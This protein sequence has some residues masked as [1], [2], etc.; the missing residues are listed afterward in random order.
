MTE[1]KPLFYVNIQADTYSDLI[2]E[3]AR[4]GEPLLQAALTRLAA[5]L[6]PLSTGTSPQA[7]YY[8]PPPAPPLSTET[9]E[10]YDT[11]DPV[12][13]A[14]AG[15]LEAV[16]KP[17]RRAPGRPPKAAPPAEAPPPKSTKVVSQKPTGDDPEPEQELSLE[18]KT[19]ILSSKGK[20]VYMKTG[21]QKQLQEIYGRYNLASK[22]DALQAPAEVFNR[23]VADLDAALAAEPPEMF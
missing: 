20:A 6:P 7:A 10:S 19:A 12:E 13:A 15:P 2:G 21:D 11:R 1:H 14:P 3:I 5:P 23:V 22:A 8:P 16:G 18:A 17:P 9:P 4:L